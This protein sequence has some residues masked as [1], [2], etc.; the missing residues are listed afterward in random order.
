MLA[1]P[2]NRNWIKAATRATALAWC[3]LLF[4]TLAQ[5][6]QAQFNL[7]P[8]GSAT[9]QYDWQRDSIQTRNGNEGYEAF[10]KRAQRS[11]CAKDWTLLIFMAADNDLEPYALKDL[12]EI[13]AGYESGRKAAAS[14]TLRADVVVQLDTRAKEGFRRLHL[15]QTEEVL[16]PGLRSTD[17]ASRTAAQVRSPIAEFAPE[18]D[19]TG[20][21]LSREKQFEE[22][23]RWGVRNYPSQKLMVIV[24][25]HGQG[26]GT[27]TQSGTQGGLAIGEGDSSR[28]SVPALARVLEKIVRSERA[29]RPIDV[30]ASDA[31][32][33]QMAE[34]AYEIAPSTSYII[35]SAQ[36]QSFEGLPYRRILFEL[37]T[38][39]W[40]G[41][42]AAMGGASPE[43]SWQEPWWMARM[44]PD[45][46]NAS[47]QTQGLQGRED[48]ESKE[49]LTL[50]SIESTSLRRQLIPA[51]NHLG[52]ALSGWTREDPMR[53]LTLLGVLP[54][55]LRFEGNAHE[56]GAFL[57]QLE[58][59]IRQEQ[60]LTGNLEESLPTQRLR[61]ALHETRDAMRMAVV[62]RVIGPGYF[63]RVDEKAWLSHLQS[64]SIWI[65]IQ[66]GELSAR[67]TEFSRSHL[68]LEA[69]LWAGWISN[70]YSP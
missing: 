37:T 7:P 18:L 41:E 17:F 66:A 33:M 57:L 61:A 53:K 68:W 21:P 10:K 67:K 35:G 24:W 65:P 42:R 6:S 27:R 20:K 5:A 32:L 3:G 54:E 49:T 60:E 70:L 29:G 28:L 51:I 47:L 25:G 14:S 23:L 36:V 34:V 2:I 12:Q 16:R 38:G 69:P 13:E 48:R 52:G 64:L 56:L 62:N 43:N 15:F 31:C 58:L 46:M 9:A 44:V 50:A 30:Y 40:N 63:N 26:W 8:C 11:S 55:T 39:R 22:F 45:L 4:S 1:R 59:A 19:S